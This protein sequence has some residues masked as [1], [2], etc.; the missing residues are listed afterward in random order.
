[1]TEANFSNKNLGAGGAIII[2][3][4]ITNKDNGALSVLNL[5]KNS[6]GELVLPKGWTEDVDYVTFEST[7]KHTDGRE[8][9]DK[10]PGKPE[11]IIA[12]ANAIPNMG[13]ISSINLLKNK[14]GIGQAEALAS[15]LKEHPTLKSL[16]GNKGNETELDMSGKMNGSED[17]IMLT[18]EIAGSGALLSL[19]VS[20][21]NFTRGAVIP[22]R[23]RWSDSNNAKFATDT[24]G[25][26]AL[27]SGI[28]D[29]GAL[30]VLD[31]SNNGIGHCDDLPSGWSLHLENSA[32]YRYKHTDG[33]HQE[34]APD[35][36]KSTGAIAI[37]DA[38]K[39]MGAMSLLNLSANKL[40]TAGVLI[41]CEGLLNDARS[42]TQQ[43]CIS[44]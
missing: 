38:I 20:S 29:N 19:D 34:S 27:I 3:A 13:A 44:L 23:E 28:K 2:S 7:Y 43:T 26:I 16:C 24:A 35:G 4:W 30:S 37:A 5:A 36:A 8:Q 22:G 14:I 15:M 25:V 39:D 41:V 6:L 11:G 17:A 12:I 9:K 42:D 10:H 21:N 33:R 32:E 40:G 1:M 18:A 31:V